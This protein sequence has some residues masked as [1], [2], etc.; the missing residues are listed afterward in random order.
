M[1][2][3][4]APSFS[5]ELFA[6]LRELKQHNEREWFNANK[7]RYEGELKEPALAFI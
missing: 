5:P 3:A 1:S 2:T 7:A 4:E 6:F